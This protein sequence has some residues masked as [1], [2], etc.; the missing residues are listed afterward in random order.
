LPC[1]VKEPIYQCVRGEDRVGDV[2]QGVAGCVACGC[3][4]GLPS[5]S[6]MCV[7]S[8]DPAV[9]RASINLLAAHV[10]YEANTSSV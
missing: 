2:S 3:N 9:L 8:K 7:K 6:V 5:W 4:G 1:V 10:F